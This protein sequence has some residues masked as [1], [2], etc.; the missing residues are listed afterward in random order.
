[1][2]VVTVEQAALV[3]I[4][5]ALQHRL[6]H[7]EMEIPFLVIRNI[8]RTKFAIEGFSESIAYELDPFGI[9]VVLI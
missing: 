6:K 8:L 3:L 5:Q 9:K 7:Q 4:H 1:M 2:N